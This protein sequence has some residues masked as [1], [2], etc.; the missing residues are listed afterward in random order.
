VDINEVARY[1]NLYARANPVTATAVAMAESGG[2]E[3]ATNRNDDGSTDSGLW[4]INSVH[5]RSHPTW[6]VTWLQNPANNAEA[7]RVVSNGGANWQP[8]TAFRNGKYKS[9][10]TQARAAVDAT[11][12]STGDLSVSER[13]GDVAG[14]VGQL[15][16]DPLSVLAD[17]AG[18]L[19][20]GFQAMLDI[21][22]GI[23]G[24]IT[25]PHNWTRVAY[26]LAGGALVVMAGAAV[27][28]DTKAGQAATRAVR[29][30]R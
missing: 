8:W 29:A 9:H 4:Q 20:G 17:V 3:R 2:N 28:S 27:A 6:T 15:A 12:G 16:S 19:T 1:A 26:V 10:L 13:L 14:G 7:M 30:V 25:D 18:A 22:N 11:S 21:V 23:G 5:L 24:W